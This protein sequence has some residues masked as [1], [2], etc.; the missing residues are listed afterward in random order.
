MRKLLLVIAIP[1][2]AG[3]VGFV[4]ADDIP[5]WIEDTGSGYNLWVKVSIPA[6]GSVLL[7]ISKGG[8]SPNG[9]AVFE[10]FDDSRIICKE[11]KS[12][13]AIVFKVKISEEEF[14]V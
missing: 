9:E 1:I 10:L 11:F 4:Y 7:N 5:Y 12:E 6:G 8:G 14:F 13:S 2:I 3:L